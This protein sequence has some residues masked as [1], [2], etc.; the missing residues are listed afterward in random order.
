MTKK[1]S[2]TLKCPANAFAGA[3]ERIIEFSFPCGLGGLISFSVDKDG[4]P[5]VE[6]YRVDEG[7]KIRAPKLSA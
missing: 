1:P 7:V 6:A 5:V 4:A 3:D 2:V